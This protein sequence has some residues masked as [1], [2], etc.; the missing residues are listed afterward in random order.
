MGLK[1]TD[2]F[3]QLKPYPSSNGVGKLCYQTL[4]GEDGWGI[5][6][7]PLRGDRDNSAY[8]KRTWLTETLHD[9]QGGEPY[10]HWSKRTVRNGQ[11]SMVNQMS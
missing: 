10:L 1:G 7:S 2:F 9:A 11:G 5:C 4:T 6:S 3:N 8:W